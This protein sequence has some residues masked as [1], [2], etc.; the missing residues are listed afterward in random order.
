MN[1]DN[2]TDKNLN[3]NFGLLYYDKI[4]FLGRW[5]IIQNNPLIICDIAHNIDAIKFANAVGALS[6]TKIGTAKSMPVRS[7]IDKLF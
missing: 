3:S 5:T 1:L 4:D 2:H 6:T 7:E